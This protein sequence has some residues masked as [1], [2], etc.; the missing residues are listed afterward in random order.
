MHLVERLLRQRVTKLAVLLRESCQRG[1]TVE[2]NSNV[3]DTPRAAEDA[4]QCEGQAMTQRKPVRREVVLSHQFLEGDH[5]WIV[6]RQ[7]ENGISE[8]APTL[9]CEQRFCGIHLD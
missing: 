6:R 8:L 7:I 2:G 9:P 5:D 1:R 4:M 3:G